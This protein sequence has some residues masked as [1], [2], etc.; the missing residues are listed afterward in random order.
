MRKIIFLIFVSSFILMTT[1]CATFKSQIKGKFNSSADKNHGA[2][3]VSV[4]FIMSHFS[5]SKGYDAIPK[6]ENKR[7]IISGFDDI[8]HDAL[9]EFSNIKKYST[10]TEY[11][12]DVNKPERRNEVDYL[13]QNHDFFIK[14]KIMKEKIFAKHFLGIIVSTASLT[15]FPIPYTYSY[16]VEVNVFNSKNQLI[17]TY[18]RK[19]TLTKWVQ[20]LLLFAYPFYPEKRQKEEMYV[21]F[22]HNIF[23][24]IESEKI[25][26]KSNDQK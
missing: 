17:N 23:K 19:A 22:L 12:S 13:M 10:F 2:D 8:F 9:N 15:L 11:A 6:L 3:G 16:S 25:L 14:I 5:Q 26:K 21:A 24:Q 7:Q 18:T 1:G 20:T 4:L